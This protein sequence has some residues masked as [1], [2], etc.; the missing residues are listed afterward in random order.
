MKVTGYPRTTCTVFTSKLN[1]YPS[2][3][4]KTVKA[5]VVPSLTGV[6]RT[7]RVLLFFV[8]RLVWERVSVLVDLVGH[9]YP[10]SFFTTDDRRRLTPTNNV[11][12]STD[13]VIP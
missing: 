7:T 3:R 13:Y 6:R 1:V 2:V 4:Y 9:L 8:V 10:E 11:S 12:T 5:G